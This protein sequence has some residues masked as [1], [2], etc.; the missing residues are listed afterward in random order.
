MTPDTAL[1]GLLMLLGLAFAFAYVV[2]EPA[3]RDD[4]TDR[5]VRIERGP[6]R[7]L[8]GWVRR[9]DG[10]RLSIETT[11]SGKWFTVDRQDV[12]ALFGD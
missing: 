4:W 12:T 3:S 10:D 2:S 7:G 1:L 9:V 5:L 6:H 11:P 8:S